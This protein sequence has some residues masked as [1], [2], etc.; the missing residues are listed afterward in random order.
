MGQCH[1]RAS[2]AET[3]GEAR[4][5]NVSKGIAQLPEVALDNRLRLA[6]TSAALTGSRCFGGLFAASRR[7]REG[8]NEPPKENVL[9]GVLGWCLHCAGTGNAGRGADLNEVRADC[10][11]RATGSIFAKV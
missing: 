3:R 5:L 10:W 2:I 4:H 11:Q 9:W 7:C 6:W 8:G 1:S